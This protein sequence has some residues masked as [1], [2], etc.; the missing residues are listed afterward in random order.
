ML[1]SCLAPDCSAVAREA[2]ADGGCGFGRDASV[3]FDAQRGLAYIAFMV[4]GLASLAPKHQQ[5]THWI[6]WW[7]HGLGLTNLLSLFK[8]SLPGL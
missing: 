8:L 6:D 5:Q 1:A 3:A 4:R 2:V 7:A